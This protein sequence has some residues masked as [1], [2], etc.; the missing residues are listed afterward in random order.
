MKCPSCDFI[1]RDEVF[2]TPPKCPKCGA[3]YAKAMRIKQLRDQ[4]ESAEEQTKPSPPAVAAVAAEARKQSDAEAGD[5]QE[6][7]II[8]IDMPFSSMVFLMVKLA[9]ASIP[10]LIILFV[11]FAGFGSII[12]TL[13]AL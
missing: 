9:L 2:G 12:G 13:I 10:A 11:L 1:E 7:A 6:V 4:Q 8:D 3:A 5:Y